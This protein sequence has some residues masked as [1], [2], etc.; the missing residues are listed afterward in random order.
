MKFSELFESKRNFFHFGKS[1]RIVNWKAVERIKCFAALKNTKQNNIWHKEGD[2]FAHTKLVTKAM[3][4][5]LK[6][7]N[8]DTY[9]E[10]WLMMMSAAL[11][12][13][14]GKAETT[15]WDENKNN[16]SCKNHGAASARIIR[17]LFYDEDFELREKVCFMARRHMTL[18]HI[19]DN[20]ET[21]VRDL[22]N[23]SM[24]PVTVEDM[25]LLKEA[26]SFGSK[27]DE[28]TSDK[29]A[30]TSKA[31]RIFGKYHN[32][33]DRPYSFENDWHRLMFFAY[34]NYLLPSEI[35]IPK[36]S[37]DNDFTVYMM[38]GVPGAGKDW[39]IE[40]NLN[41]IPQLSRDIIR[42]EIGLEGEKP[43]GNKSQEEEVTRIF[44]ERM[45]EYL[46]NKQSFVI[47]NTNGN[48]RYRDDFIK[49][50]LPH[51]AKIVY[52]YCESPSLEENMNRRRGM[53]PT[54]VITRMWK[55]FEFPY[56]NEYYE[57]CY[58]VQRP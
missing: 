42:T 48:K 52:V 9:S 36:E 18:H 2:A 47:N 51:F 15:K 35:G 46:K 6:K 33:L 10:Y 54:N 50:I 32:C 25:V 34:K 55:E 14:L 56:K 23:L 13:D 12:H 41:N 30:E 19:F 8:I 43:M 17:T 28:E 58:N 39:Y 37:Y 45:E 57:I 27:N 53:M 31:I 22:I 29:I 40:H 49:K 11:C 24:G 16:W 20:S 7:R 4:R 38:L 1:E 3:E 5:L 26:D 44:N 21:I